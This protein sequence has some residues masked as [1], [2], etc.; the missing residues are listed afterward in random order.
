MYTPHTK[1]H[2]HTIKDSEPIHGFSQN[3]P[4][5]VVSCADSK[6]L[7]TV[8]LE[9]LGEKWEKRKSRERER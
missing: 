1:T 4:L 7:A 3:P 8:A 6:L 5:P 9:S 2:T